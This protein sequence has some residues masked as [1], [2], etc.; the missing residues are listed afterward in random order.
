MRRCRIRN[1]CIILSVLIFSIVAHDASHAMAPAP[2]PAPSPQQPP[3]QP[4]LS[5]G[6]WQRFAL[7]MSETGTQG[8]PFDVQL[9]GRFTHVPSGRTVQAPGY[10]AG[11]SVWRIYFMPEQIGE[12]SYA[13]VSPQPGLNGQSGSFVCVESGLPGRL[14]PTQNRWQ[15]SDAGFDVP[16]ILPVSDWFKVERSEEEI[17][18][19]I[20][21]ARDVVGARAIGI[22]LVYFFEREQSAMAYDRGR[23][24]QRF[25]TAYWDRL[26][27]L[28]DAA[29]DAGMGHYV[30]FYSDDENDPSRNG[31]RPQT[32]EELRL[33]RYAVARLGPYPIVIW[34]TGIDIGEYRSDEWIEWFTNHMLEHDPW[35]HPVGSRTSG[36]SGGIHPTNATY[37]ADGTSSL[38]SRGEF[39]QTWR[40][41]SVPT[42]MTDNWREDYS[43]G[44]FTPEV[45]RRAVWQMGLTG[46][47]ALMVSGNENLGYLGRNYEADLRAAPD[48]GRAVH[49][50]RSQ[51]QRFAWLAPHDEMATASTEVMLSADPEYEYVA[52]LPRGGTVTIHLSGAG[53]QFRTTWFDPLTGE[54]RDAGVVS[55]GRSA[56]FNANGDREM[57]LHL[58]ES[59]LTR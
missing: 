24:G 53:K 4:G 30:R 51:V 22:T 16:V 14:V 13:T 33:L 46:G 17:D 26:N 19:F 2:G 1:L 45:I 9:T 8:N 37:F 18:A 10:Y 39:V 49:F 15:L 3:S 52:Y 47:T 50:F 56:D 42:A 32:E 59:S 57:V 12:W 35:A 11:N 43:R 28:F 44:G 55:G 21:W 29:R 48:V 31:I 6:K 40:S 23:E 27:T 34:D 41:R 20:A 36:G 5:V 58:L 54:T 25:N 38:P 7:E